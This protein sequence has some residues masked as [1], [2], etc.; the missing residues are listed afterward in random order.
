MTGCVP[1]SPFGMVIASHR[2]IEPH[3][4]Y[5]SNHGESRSSWSQQNLL[6]PMGTPHCLSI[7]LFAPKMDKTAIYNLNMLQQILSFFRIF[8][9]PYVMVGLFSSGL[10]YI[11]SIHM[12]LHFLL[13]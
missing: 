5:A 9:F 4:R 2:A 3:V 1:S 8:I 10:I 7:G 12:D 6:H 11:Q 13:L